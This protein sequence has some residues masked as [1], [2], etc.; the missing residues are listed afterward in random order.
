MK[1]IIAILMIMLVVILSTVAAF[2]QTKMTVDK[3]VPAGTY[4]LQPE[5]TT[6]P[7]DPVCNC[8]AEVFKIKSVATLLPGA[9]AFVNLTKINGEWQFDFGIPAGANGQC[10]TCTGLPGGGTIT[11]WY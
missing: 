11:N 6:P 7:T 4:V 8:P 10:P 2:S 3:P 1:Q 9:T 5:G